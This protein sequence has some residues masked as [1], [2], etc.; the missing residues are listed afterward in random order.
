MTLALHAEDGSLPL[1]LTIQ[2]AYRELLN[3]CKN[4]A[5]VV[6]NSMA[7]PQ[8]LRKKTPVVRAVVATWVSRPPMQTRMMEA[9]DIPKTSRCQSCLWNKGKRNR[10]MSCI[11]EDWNL[12]HLSWWV[13]PGLLAEYHDVFALQPSKLGCTHSTKHVINVTHNTPFRE[14][15]RQ[16]PLLLVGEI[17]THLWEMLDSGAI[18]PNQSAW[19]NV[20]L[21]VQKKDRDLHFCIDFHHLNAHTKKDSYLL[22]RIQEALESLVD[23]GHFHA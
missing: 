7:Y 19:F 10:L 20:V 1:G 4:V 14:Q 18:C 22:P 6:R 16:I 2:N 9:L 15:F 13:L 17:C 11:W 5:V 12:G 3:G 8:T 21:L 23:A